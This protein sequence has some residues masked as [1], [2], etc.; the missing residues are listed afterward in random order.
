M[1]KLHLLTKSCVRGC[2][3]YSCRSNYIQGEIACPG[4]TDSATHFM[5]GVFG[6]FLSANLLSQVLLPAF[7]ASWFGSTVL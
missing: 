2:I 6:G 4:H 1:Q 7:I 5:L 3:P